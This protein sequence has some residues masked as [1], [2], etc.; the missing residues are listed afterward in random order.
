M[1]LRLTPRAK[2]DVIAIAEYVRAENPV[3]AERVRGAILESLQLLTD[4]P[5]IG[6]RQNIEGVCKHVTR[7]Y[8]YLVYYSID[9]FAHE[10][11]ILTV[12]HPSRAQPFRD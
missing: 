3:A 5:E 6:R 7:K 1:R 10:I 9:T 2:Q 12:Q 4:F 11:A 8:G